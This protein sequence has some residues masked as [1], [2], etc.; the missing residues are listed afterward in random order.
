MWWRW[1]NNRTIRSDSLV[2]K[3]GTTWIVR[4]FYGRAF[5]GK[6]GPGPTGMAG[7]MIV[8][9]KGDTIFSDSALAAA[10]YGKSISNPKELPWIVD[11]TAMA[12]TN[13][14]RLLVA[15]NG[16]D[17]NVRVIKVP[18]G[19]PPRFDTILSLG[20]KG[21]V[22]AGP[23]PGRA[24][25]RRF[26]GIRGLG[27]DSV[28][29]IYVGNTGMPMQVGGG[30]DIRC[31]NRLDSATPTGLDTAKLVWKVQGLAF[32]NTADFDPD[33]NGTSVYKNAERFHMDWTQPPG[34]SWSLAAVTID[35]FKYPNDPRLNQSLEEVWV[36]RIGG[37]LFLFLG[38]MT[39][40]GIH[41]IR[42]EP[43]SEIGI[44]VARFGMTDPSLN[45]PWAKGIAPTW[46]PKVGE[47]WK[48]R[49]MWVDRN[50]DGHYQ[51]D[52]FSTFKVDC[53][54]SGTS[55]SDFGDILFG[56]GD[57]ST[58]PSN[59][60]DANGIPA[61]D[62]AK[63]TKVPASDL[64]PVDTTFP[65][66]VRLG[67]G[68]LMNGRQ[69]R[70]HY[71]ARSDAMLITSGRKATFF[72]AVARWDDW[73]KPSR[74]LSWVAPIDCKWPSDGKD[75]SLDVNS[76]DAISPVSITADTQYLY[77][78]YLDKGPDTV[79]VNMIQ[80][81][82]QLIWGTSR[83]ALRGEITVWDMKHLT[84]HYDSTTKKSWPRPTRVGAI[85]PDSGVGH[86]AGATDVWYSL[87]VMVRSDGAR[88]IS[89][90]EDGWGKVFIHRWC[91]EGEA[92]A[93]SLGAKPERFMNSGLRFVAS[94]RD[95]RILGGIL[96][97]TRIMATDLRGRR[98][99]GWTSGSEPA[100]SLPSTGL[101]LLEVRQDGQLLATHKVM[102]R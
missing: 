65:P 26:W 23:V 21:G 60:L 82:T 2:T 32:V 20:V 61:W 91:P 41:V 50:G 55:I 83:T 11:P 3:N 6:T 44:P 68:Y 102:A 58:I 30:T 16:P 76:W 72:D 33:S 42:F 9:S 69:Y 53:P 94:G 93:K 75:V 67:A 37:K 12:E 48:L 18:L 31:F 97:G 8:S 10:K 5:L 80:D 54:P 29:R 24:G 87:N 19:G 39:G 73:S 47:N 43:G 70:M 79:V 77:V 64:F 96:P 89:A 22:F 63:I 92:C 27:T 25:D 56:C 86:R 62:A 7:A 14:G 28:G 36:R 66:D 59:G 81:P 51:A 1:Y 13:D 38:D 88:L 84:Q 46:D 15:S 101:F 71:I 85:I 35:P 99:A 78:N 34:R 17:Q 4:N 100:I 52:E 45:D 98:V 90:E 49:W 95:V 57:V 40:S 74:K